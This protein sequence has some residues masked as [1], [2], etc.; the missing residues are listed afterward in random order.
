MGG[1]G[2]GRKPTHNDLYH[3]LVR[4]H[5]RIYDREITRIRKEHNNC[6][7]KEAQRIRKERMKKKITITRS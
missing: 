2:S 4:E 6:S 1:E 3:K 5:Q 7:Y